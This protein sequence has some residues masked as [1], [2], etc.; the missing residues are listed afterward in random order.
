MHHTKRLHYASNQ[1][2]LGYGKYID[3]STLQ[4]IYALPRNYTLAEM[5]TH[6]QMHQAETASLGAPSSLIDPKTAISHSVQE[7]VQQH[8]LSQHSRAFDYG[9]AK[10]A[11]MAAGPSTQTSWNQS[12][13]GD[14]TILHAGDILQMRTAQTDRQYLDA[15]TISNEYHDYEVFG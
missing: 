11:G 5:Q 7:Y 2:G 4:E 13:T 1:D 3:A 15:P 14:K 12:H 9:D 8:D 10:A 6:W